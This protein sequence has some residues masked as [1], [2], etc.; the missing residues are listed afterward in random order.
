MMQMCYSNRIFYGLGQ[1]VSGMGRWRLQADKFMNFIIPIPPYD[2][3]VEIAAY[4]DKKCSEIDAIIT[5]KE[6]FLTE[7]DKYKK[8]LIYECVTGKRE[9]PQNG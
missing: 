7:L 8:S 9:V 4:L 2:E 3:Q 6:T 5:K 1:G